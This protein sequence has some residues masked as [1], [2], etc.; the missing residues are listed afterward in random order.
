M[1]KTA[2]FTF[3]EVQASVVLIAVAMGGLAMMLANHSSQ[4]EALRKIEP[5]FS[6]ISYVPS[7]EGNFML[8][9]EVSTGTVSARY[10]AVVESVTRNGG[11]SQ[12]AVIALY[13]N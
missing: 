6:Y 8:V 12:T 2:G 11:T 3:L 5:I 13:P 4:N 7:A 1:R 10:Q 9:T